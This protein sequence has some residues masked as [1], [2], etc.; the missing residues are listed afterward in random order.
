MAV[1]SLR[2]SRAWTIFQ[3]QAGAP[4]TIYIL[5]L[6]SGL[7]FLQQMIRDR[8]AE[9][10]PRCLPGQMMEFHCPAWTQLIRTPTCDWRNGSAHDRVMFLLSKQQSFEPIFSLWWKIVRKTRVG[11][12]FYVDNVRLLTGL[13]EF[14]FYRLVLKQQWFPPLLIERQSNIKTS[15]I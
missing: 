15:A 3:L 7:N 1:P 10:K 4:A 6:F 12:M 14:N 13:R 2:L 5:T 9:W 11:F 8:C